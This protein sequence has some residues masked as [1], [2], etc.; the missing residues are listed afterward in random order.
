MSGRIAKVPELVQLAEEF[1]AALMLDDAHAVGVIGPEGQGSASSFGLLGP[2]PPSNRHILQ[3][4]RL[5]GRLRC[6]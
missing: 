3:E 2:Y 6:R 1:D 5:L 4:L